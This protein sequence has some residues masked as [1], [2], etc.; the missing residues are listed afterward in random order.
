[1]ADRD[2]FYQWADLSIMPNIEVAGDA[3][4]FGIAAIE[5]GSWGQPLLTSGIEGVADAIRPGETA[6]VYSDSQHCLRLL[7]A[8][9]DGQRPLGSRDAIEAAVQ[10]HYDWR[11][12]A[13]QYDALIRAVVDGRSTG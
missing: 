9:L 1:M 2:A 11:S 12:I 7:D 4:G 6:M 3:E 13:V 5:C 8:F 10:R